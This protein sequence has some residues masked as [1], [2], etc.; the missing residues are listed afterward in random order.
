MALP[1]ALAPTLAIDTRKTLDVTTT[2]RDVE[3]QH[4]GER[5]RREAKPIPVN[6]A[7]VLREIKSQTLLGTMKMV[8][9]IGPGDQMKVDRSAAGVD[10][11]APG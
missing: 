9:R 10:R 6:A 2:A 7:I 3:G 11:R 4:D 8:H 5:H 1:F